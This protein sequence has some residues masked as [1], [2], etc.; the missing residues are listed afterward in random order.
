MEMP[1]RRRGG[2]P[3]RTLA[4]IPGKTWQLRGFTRL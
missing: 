1:W 4:S 2:G 3:A